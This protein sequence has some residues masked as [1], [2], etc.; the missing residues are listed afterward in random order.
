VAASWALLAIAMEDEP[1]SICVGTET[2]KARLEYQAAAWAMCN[3]GA[4]LVP[5]SRDSFCELTIGL[6]MI[7]RQDGKWGISPAGV[8]PPARSPVGAPAGPGAVR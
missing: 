1:P 3:D 8:G 6:G 4:H 5:Y 7:R 2:D